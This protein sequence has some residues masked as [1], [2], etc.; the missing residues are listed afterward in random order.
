MINE[1][2]KLLPYLN[3]ETESIR[4]AQG[5]YKLPQTIKEGFKQ[6]KREI[7]WRKKQ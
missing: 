7:S 3:G 4:I 1:I 2:I 5:K 6:A